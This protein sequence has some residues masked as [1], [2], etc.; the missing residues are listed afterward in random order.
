MTKK[1]YLLYALN[2]ADWLCTLILLRT[3]GFY[4]ANPLM[5]PFADSLPQSFLLKCAAPAIVMGAIIWCLRKLD[6]RDLRR[7]DRWIA[8]TLTFYTALCIG[9]I[10]NFILLFLGIVLD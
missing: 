9:H 2:V 10:I 8:F 5:R 4:E 7:L 3:G 6:V 1:L